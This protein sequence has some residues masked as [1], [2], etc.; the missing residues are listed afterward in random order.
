MAK[1]NLSKLAIN[2]EANSHIR[3]IQKDDKC[4]WCQTNPATI[5]LSPY[6]FCSENCKQDMIIDC[7]EAQE[8]S[9]SQVK[10]TNENLQIETESIFK[11]IFEKQCGKCPHKQDSHKM[12]CFECCPIKRAAMK[13]FN[14]SG[15]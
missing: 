6:V 12:N 2:S 14:L 13:S 1:L 5:I 3:T 11:I 10:Y 7:F 9:M 15:Y 8:Q 4:D